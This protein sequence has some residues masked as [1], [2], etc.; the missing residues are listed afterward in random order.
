MRDCKVSVIIPTYNRSELIGE[1]L[2]SV[3]SQTYSNWECIVV[4][5]GSTDK[6][7]EVVTAYVARDSRFQFYKRP[8]LRKRGASACRNYGLEKSTGEFIQFLDSDDI[9]DKTKFEEQIK[10]S[11]KVSELDVITC[12]WGSFISS[13]SV[14]VKTNY[15]AYRDFKP[16]VNLLRNFG[17]RNEYF[18]PIVYLTS[19]K[20]IESAG[21]WNEN[22]SHNDDG[23][24]FT[25]ILLNTNHVSFCETTSA[26]Y[27]A[28]NTGRLSLLDDPEKVRSAIRSWKLIEGHLE[29]EHKKIAAIYV[30]NGKKNVYE[31]IRE[32]Y[33]EIINENYSFF[34]EVIPLNQRLFKFGR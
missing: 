33:P 7:Q 20:L 16:G 28:G 13:T 6:T 1:T 25:R 18:P 17:K 27:R 5:D 23:E 19:R 32:C 8:K 30:K 22:V 9:L 24:F 34:K 29:K 26:Y 11:K 10:I 31:Q 12:K 3:V 15:G 21:E 4:D 14:R 2:E